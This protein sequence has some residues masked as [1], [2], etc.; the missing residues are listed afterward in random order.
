MKPQ[1][2]KEDVPVK[3]CTCLT[4]AQW[5]LCK[6]NGW[7]WRRVI[8]AGIGV[9]TAEGNFGDRIRMLEAQV[10]AMRK[11]REARDKLITDLQNKR[12]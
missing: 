2:D 11:Q 6:K 10:E 4:Y 5:S 9:L 8:D 12:R 7:T 3:I 1:P